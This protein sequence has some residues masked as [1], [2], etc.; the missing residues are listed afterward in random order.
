MIHNLKKLLLT[1]SDED[2]YF[3]PKTWFFW[4][5][6]IIYFFLFSIVGH[7]MEVPY[8][9]FMDLAF[10]IVEEDYAVWTDPWYLPYWVYGVGATI[11]TLLLM[12]LKIRILKVRKTFWG[13]VIEYLIVATILCAAMELIIGLII[14]QPDPVTGKHPFWDNTQLPGSIGGQ[15]WIVNDILLALVSLIYVWIVFPFMQKA[16]TFVGE[17]AMNQ[18]FTCTLVLCAFVCFASYALPTLQNYF[19]Q[20]SPFYESR[21]L[22]K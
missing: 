6:I 15:A 2:K 18:A 12:P 7:W 11:I 21:S 4:R 8:C 20:D 5:G 13:A 16:S 3:E 22:P 17:K 1:K 14:N 10:S 19:G 9:W